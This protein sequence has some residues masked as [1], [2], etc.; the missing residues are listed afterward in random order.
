MNKPAAMGQTKKRN[1]N[2][3]IR[4][5]RPQVKREMIMIMPASLQNWNGF[6]E[7]YHRS[8]D[9]TDRAYNV[10]HDRRIKISHLKLSSLIH[11]LFFSLSFFLSSFFLRGWEVRGI[12]VA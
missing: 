6:W 3:L 7:I 2:C 5:V 1:N 10:M 9:L 11:V 12:E 8:S 4:L